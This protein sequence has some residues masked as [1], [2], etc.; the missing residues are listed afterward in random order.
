[1][2]NLKLTINS[3][4]LEF[5]F[6]LGFL[7]EVLEFLDMSMSELGEKVTKNPYKYIP[8]LVYHSAKYAL[9]LEGKE[10]DFTQKDVI[11]WIEKDGGINFGNKFYMR[12]QEKFIE[13]LT[14]DIPKNEEEETGNAEPVE[15]PESEKK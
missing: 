11:E 3:R 7:G 13:S 1:M 4:E 8:I 12:F 10:A 2:K 5:T 14:K 9:D 15:A 6:G